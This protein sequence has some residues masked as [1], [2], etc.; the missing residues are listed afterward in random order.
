MGTDV[1][2]NLDHVTRVFP[3]Q[4]A[5][6]QRKDETVTHIEV[7][8]SNLASPIVVEGTLDTFLGWW[9]GPTDGYDGGSEN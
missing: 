6:R 5:E 9:L 2:I 3:R 7:Y 4:Q 8:V 1:L